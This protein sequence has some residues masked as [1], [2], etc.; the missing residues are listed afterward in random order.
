MCICSA[1]PYVHMCACACRCEQQFE[2]VEEV[3]PD[4]S[5]TLAQQVLYG[6]TR[7]GKPVGGSRYYLGPVVADK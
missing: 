4:G 6:G 5:K 7:D 3:Q 1:G 2:S